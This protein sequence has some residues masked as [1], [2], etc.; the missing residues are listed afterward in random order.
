MMN[1]RVN[2]TT[3]SRTGAIL[4]LGFAVSGSGCAPT[5]GRLPVYRVA[6]QVSV[7]NEAPE[8]AL[9]V[10]HPTGTAPAEVRPSAKVQRDGSFELTTFEANDGAPAGDYV[11]TL[12]WNKLVKQRGNYSAGPNLVPRAYASATTSPWKVTVAARPNTLSPLAIT[13]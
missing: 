3:S 9:V 12:Q 7:R 2:W 11:A 5:D 6:G 8:G 13:R 1:R 4:A 10:L